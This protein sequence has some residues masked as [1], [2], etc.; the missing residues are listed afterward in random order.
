[1]ISG[2]SSSLPPCRVVGCTQQCRR[3]TPPSASAAETVGTITGNVKLPPKAGSPQTEVLVLKPGQRAPV[4][5]K[6]ME[7][8]SVTVSLG[9]L[10]VTVEWTK[11]G[12]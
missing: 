6:G 8:L 4:L 9:E 7:E 2:S 3:P 5:A 1:M 11:A 12:Y 10:L